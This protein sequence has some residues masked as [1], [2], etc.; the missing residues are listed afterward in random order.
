MLG[1]I[2][3]ERAVGQQRERGRSLAVRADRVGLVDEEL[4]EARAGRRWAARI[5]LVAVAGERRRNPAPRRRE[6]RAPRP[7]S[8]PSPER[9]SARCA[10]LTSVRLRDGFERAHLRRRAGWRAARRVARTAAPA[11]RAA[12]R[13]TPAP[14]AAGRA[15]TRRA[16]SR[17][18]RAIDEHA[19]RPRRPSAPGAR[20]RRARDRVACVRSVGARRR[21]VPRAIDAVEPRWLRPRQRLRFAPAAPRATQRHC[22]AA[23]AAPQNPRAAEPARQRRA[24]A[25]TGAHALARRRRAASSAAPCRRLRA[26]ARRRTTPAAD[27]C[28]RDLVFDEAHELVRQLVRR[29]VADVGDDERV[30]L[31]QPVVVAILDDRALPHRRMHEQRALDLARRHPAPRDLEQIVAAPAVEEVVVV[32]DEEAIARSGA[33]PRRSA[34]A[35][36]A[37]QS[38]SAAPDCP[39][40]ST[41]RA[42]NPRQRPAHRQR[43]PRAGVFESTNESASVMPKPCRSS[44]PNSSCTRFSTAIG[45]VSPPEMAWRTDAIS[46]GR[47][48]GSSA[49]SCASCAYSDGVAAKIVGTNAVIISNSVRGRARDGKRNVAAPAMQWEEQADAE[50]VR[51]RQLGRR[52]HAVVGVDAEHVLGVGG[53]RVA[54][55]RVVVVRRRPRRIAGRPE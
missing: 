18:A 6:R 1:I 44:T 15:R 20:T 46:F 45:S 39:P 38:P 31:R 17:R 29:R 8:M 37:R 51:R 49:K 25:S 2:G 21:R 52:Q 12:R 14:R 54:R 34:R 27:T 42:S 5:E 32:V 24:A 26:A 22:C 16:R 13:R 33:R 48:D 28:R 19:A 23:D 47:G 3:R 50:P 11:P 36:R 41:T 35:P 55:R 4:A 10:A 43:A 53:E 30:R 7:A 40:S 9:N